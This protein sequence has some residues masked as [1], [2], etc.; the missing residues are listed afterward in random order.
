MVRDYHVGR[1]LSIAYGVPESL[2][3]PRIPDPLPP[4]PVDI[5]ACDVLAA[6]AAGHQVVDRAGDIQ[7]L[8]RIRA[9]G[10]TACGTALVEGM[11]AFAAPLSSKSIAAIASGEEL[12]TPPIG[13]IDDVT[14]D[15]AGAAAGGDVAGS[16]NNPLSTAFAPAVRV[17]VI[18]TCPLT[19]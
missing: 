16:R 15:V 5:I 19:A 2:W 12:G 9:T 13:S 6:I 3:C 1:Q 17:K 8:H 4:F 11:A 18:T 14:T 7:F 10:L